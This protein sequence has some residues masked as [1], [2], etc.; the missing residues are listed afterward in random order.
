MARAAFVH[1]TKDELREMNASQLDRYIAVLRT[2]ASWLRGPAR[3]S[4]EKHI[5]VAIKLRELA[6][7]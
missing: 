5:E 4:A 3:K 2:R 6:N 1:K 7:A